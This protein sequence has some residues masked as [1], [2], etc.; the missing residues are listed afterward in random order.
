LVQS[1][2]SPPFPF[3]G[4][5]I[6]P[7]ETLKRRNRADFSFAAI[8]SSAV[9]APPGEDGWVDCET[10]TDEVTSYLSTYA[11]YESRYPSLAASEEFSF[12]IS[13]AQPER[14]RPR[15][16]LYSSSGEFIGDFIPDATVTYSAS[17]VGLSFRAGVQIGRLV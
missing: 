11:P 17:D 16:M 3:N 2:T 12:E 15:A 7:V 5:Q 14:M 6:F 8:S 4:D 9:Q 1:A 10:L 13:P